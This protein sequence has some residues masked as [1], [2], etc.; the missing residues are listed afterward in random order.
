M[1][2]VLDAQMRELKCGIC[3]NDAA[4]IGRYDDHD[5]ETCTHKGCT[6]HR[7]EPACNECCGHGCEDGN[8]TYLTD[9]DGEYTEEAK[10]RV[11]VLLTK[12]SP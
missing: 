6:Q 9:E 1:G 3:G 12:D 4:C 2:E 5:E 7:D 8:C 10:A 11:G